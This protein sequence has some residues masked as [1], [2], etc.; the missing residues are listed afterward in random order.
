MLLD[1]LER[2]SEGEREREREKR[3]H[4]YSNLYLNQTYNVIFYIHVKTKQKSVALLKNIKIIPKQ[5]A[6]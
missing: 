4:N 1:L 5:S 3:W 2:D 6:F